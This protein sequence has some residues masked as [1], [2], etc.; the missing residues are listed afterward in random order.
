MTSSLSSLGLREFTDFLDQLHDAA[1]SVRLMGTLLATANDLGMLD[2]DERHGLFVLS[3]S[4][5]ATVQ[6]AADEAREDFFGARRALEQALDGEAEEPAGRGMSTEEFFEEVKRVARAEMAAE[7]A[8]EHARARR[9]GRA[10]RTARAALD[11]LEAAKA[12]EAETYPKLDAAEAAPAEEPAPQ[13]KP[14]RRRR[15]AAG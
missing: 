11:R 15:A 2:D 9:R 6:E 1:C 5:A 14:S 12:A 3:R 8:G 7:A 4:I 13:R 10:G